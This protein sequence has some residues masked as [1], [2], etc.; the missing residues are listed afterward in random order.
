MVDDATSEGHFPII[1]PGWDPP[2]VVD[3]LVSL[4]RDQLDDASREGDVGG[5]RV[6][7]YYEACER[8]VI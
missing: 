1:E 7:H 8:R 4:G 3:D 5:D 2:F 6:G